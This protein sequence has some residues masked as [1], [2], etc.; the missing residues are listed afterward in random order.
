M[1]KFYLKTLW[2]HQALFVYAKNLTQAKR[3]ATRKIG[4][5]YLLIFN[6]DLNLLAIKENG[7]WE[8]LC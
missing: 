8:E 4:A 3:M 1:T 6:E 7:K 2:E 5:G